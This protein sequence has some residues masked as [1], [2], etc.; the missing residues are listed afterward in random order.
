MSIQNKRLERATERILKEELQKGNLPTSKEFAWRMNEYLNEQDLSRPEFVFQAVKNGTLA[1]ASKYNKDFERIYNDLSILYENIREVHEALGKQFSRFEIEKNTIEKEIFQI[2]N[3]LRE[4][5]LLYAQGGFLTAVFDVFDTFQKFD[6]EGSHNI[7]MDTT[8]HE[9]RLVEEMTLSKRIGMPDATTFSLEG[10]FQKKET[11]L[12]GT[13]EDIHSVYA[14]QAWQ[15]LVQTKERLSI[16]GKLMLT[17]NE[18]IDMN[19]LNLSLMTVRPVVLSIEYTGDG[20]NWSKI[21]YN[22]NDI[23][24]NS[25]IDIK[26]PMIKVKKM[27]ILFKK[28]EFDEQVPDDAGYDYRYLFGIKKIEMRN[29]RFPEE[30]LFLTT[31]LK[32]DGPENYRINKVSLDV[33][34]VIPTGTDIL[35]EVALKNDELDWR[36]ISPLK[37]ENPAFPQYIDFQNIT[38]SKPTTMSIGGDL[39]LNQYELEELR[40]NGIQFY[41][42]GLIEGRNIIEGSERLFVGRN[43]WECKYFEHEYEDHDTHVP[44]LEDWKEPPTEIQFEYE[45]IDETRKQFLFEGKKGGA[46]ANYYCRSGVFYSGEQSI[47]SISPS[48]TDAIALFI[49]GEKVFEGYGGNQKVN[50]QFNQ[51]WNEIVVLVY[52]KNKKT[53]NGMTVSL[54][55]DMLG[56]F[57]HMYVSPSP[58]TKAELFDL[59]FNTKITDRSKYSVRKGEKGYEVILNYA[60]K[61]LVFDFYYDYGITGSD[62]DKEILLRATFKRE[63]SEEI[64]SPVLKRYRIQFS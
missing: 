13:L 39:A 30:G 54:D 12:N 23:E 44:S 34:E 11:K 35:Y 1:Y 16:T 5:I 59:R 14:D 46:T 15:V 19:Q 55:I 27:R 24:T 26:F 45:V 37:R 47:F 42:I 29:L 32:V 43:A 38:R 48:S 25:G 21:P 56:L 6:K 60:E 41:R 33:E 64:P 17:Y 7:L 52:G 61:D 50:I 18:G 57:D 62:G 2:E 20:I 22:E 63:G 53:V 9:V 3:S 36:G 58:M 40:T 51:G 28:A 4:K 31:P 10:S 49:N 8:R